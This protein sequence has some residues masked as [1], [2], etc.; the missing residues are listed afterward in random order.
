M[1]SDHNTNRLIAR[2]SAGD[3]SAF[4]ALWADSLSAVRRVVWAMTGNHEDT[5]DFLQETAVHALKALSTGRYEHQ[6]RFTAWVC[7]IARN[8]VLDNMRRV[9]WSV[10]IAEI[11]DMPDSSQPSPE[12]AAVT[13][14][15]A[16][17]LDAQLDECLGYE[18][19]AD[20]ERKRGHL[21]KLAFYWYYVDGFSLDDVTVSLQVEFARHGLGDIA[22]STANNWL[23]GGRLIRQ[24]VDHL[25]ENH[26]DALER[27]SGLTKEEIG[28]SPEEMRA[29]SKLIYGNRAARSVASVHG[30]DAK[31][32]RNAKKKMVGVLSRDIAEAL[33]DLRSKV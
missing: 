2:I 26:S 14:T 17:F 24:L 11:G 18:S 22:K 25:V 20:A 15:L 19:N 7:K 9:K 27:L 4:D 28:L 31:H 16:K 29:A 30:D 21:R 5:E 13:A 8:V 6:E 23:A 33:H 10:P 32:L 3:N 12:R 1:L